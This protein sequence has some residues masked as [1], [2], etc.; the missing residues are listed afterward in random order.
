MCFS[1]KCLRKY[2]IKQCLELA[3]IDTQ[4]KYTENT[5]QIH[6]H[7][8]LQSGEQARLDFAHVQFKQSPLQ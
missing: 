7:L 1:V 4:L 8:Q 3:Y 6:V 5:Y 2:P